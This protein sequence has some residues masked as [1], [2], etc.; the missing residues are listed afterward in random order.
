MTVA[1]V[2]SVLTAMRVL[3]Q[4]SDPDLLGVSE[5]AR[6][7]GL[8]KSSVQRMLVTLKEGGWVVDVRGDTTQW[9]LTPKMFRLG[10]RHQVGNDLRATALPVME[11]LRQETQE[12]VHLVTPKGDVVIVLEC[13]DSPQPVRAH[14]SP[15]DVFPLH[16]S[17]NGLAL[18]S[19]Q[20]D[21][22]IHGLIARGLTAYTP[23]TITKPAELEA[24]IGQVRVRGYAASEGQLREGVHAVAAPILVGGVG[25][26]G[27]G[28]STPAHRMSP[29]L[30]ARYG[31]LV[32]EA[33]LTIAQHFGEER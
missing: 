23:H 32:V 18:L 13:L 28:V 22:A 1:G 3:E 7:L 2:R 14:V 27:I 12:T 16:A 15:G 5:L 26:A 8:P 4:L 33:A 19:T 24:A 17:T 6:R 9:T 10:Q 25:I 31:G 20:S 30:E 21:E 11:K 29:A